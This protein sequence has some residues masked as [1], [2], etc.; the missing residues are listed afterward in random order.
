MSISPPPFD[1]VC[2]W[3]IGSLAVLVAVAWVITWS[4]GRADVRLRAGLAAALVMGISAAAALTGALTRFDRVPP[5]MAIMIVSVLTMGIVVGLSPFGRSVAATVPLRTLIGL[6]AFRLPLELLMHRAGSLG[7]MPP[8]LSYSGYN[9]DIVTG[10]G[11]LLLWLL[12]RGR[13][14]VPTWA[15]WVWNAWGYACLFVIVAVAIATSPMVRYFGEA[16]HVNTWVLYFPYV[17]LPAVLVTI[18]VAGH[19]VVTRRLLGGAGPL[20]LGTNE[21]AI[22]RNHGGDVPVPAHLHRLRAKVA[23]VTRRA[24]CGAV[25][26]ISSGCLRFGGG[27]ARSMRSSSAGV[28]AMS[29]AAEFS[30]RW[31]ARTAFGMAITSGCH[32]THASAICAAVAPRSA[33]MAAS[34]SSRAAT[35]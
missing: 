16:P 28:S 20:R 6:Q 14:S 23:V 18:A 8:E 25:Q 2:A 9:F 31:S 12:M 1:A 19:I 35:P 24:S 26:I 34:V 33:P 27:K 17:W 15:V 7:I 21:D 13:V 4:A 32:S 10:I 11:A 3:G 22:P 5:P 30:R 29:T